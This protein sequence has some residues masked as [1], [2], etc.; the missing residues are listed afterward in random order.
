MYTLIDCWWEKYFNDD[1]SVNLDC[2]YF[3]GVHPENKKKILDSYFLQNG[4][5]KWL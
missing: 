3:D 2:H 5:N 4:N 1:G